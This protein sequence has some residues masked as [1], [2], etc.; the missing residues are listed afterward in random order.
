MLVILFS[1]LC[2][3]MGF[4]ILMIPFSIA[5][6][7]GGP[8]PKWFRSWSCRKGLH[9]FKCR[10]F[11]NYETEWPEARCMWCDANITYMFGNPPQSFLTNRTKI[12]DME[13][14]IKAN[15]PT[16]PHNH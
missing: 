3:L 14:Q 7:A 1:I 2:V 4:A 5:V 13:A 11:W 16:A 6:L 12:L 9:S 15:Y 10:S 8:M